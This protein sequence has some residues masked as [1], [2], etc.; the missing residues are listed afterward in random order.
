M[1]TTEVKV[2]LVASAAVGVALLFM[3]RRKNLLHLTPLQRMAARNGL[4][5]SAESIAK[6]REFK[7]RSSDVFIVTYPKCGTTWVTMIA[8]ALRTRGNV[9]FEEITEVV[10][11]DIC[12]GDCDQDLNDEQ[13]ANPRLFK[14]HEA[15]EYVPKGAKYIYVSR[16]PLD[17]FVSFFHFLPAYMGIKPGELTMGEFANAI[18]AGVSQSGGIWGHYL[19]WWAHRNDPNVLWLC[20]EDL[21]D[22]LP[23]NV[24]KVAS[25]MGVEADDDLLAIANQRSSFAWMSAHG[26]K[27]D[28]HFLRD[29]VKA[30]MGLDDTAVTV[31]KVRKDGGKVGGRKA[32]PSEVV[33][34]LEQRWEASLG[35]LGLKDYAALRACI[36]AKK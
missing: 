5:H 27:F 32:I 31:G 25:F 15:Y 2:A 10:P 8:H 7:P 17:A 19:G 21:K 13:V 14:S 18:F 35:A 6:G 1:V 9:D 26:T 20:Y 4:M 34:L 28:D 36:T 23:G 3:Y 33:A 22:D 12:A 30:R 24:K 16:E 11:W 29:K